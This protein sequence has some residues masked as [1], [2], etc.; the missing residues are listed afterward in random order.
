MR[1]AIFTD[2]FWPQINGVT[3]SIWNMCTELGKQGHEFLIFAPKQKNDHVMLPPHKGKITIRWL[4]AKPLPTYPDYLIAYSFS[5]EDKQAMQNFHPDVIH[6]HTPFYVAKKGIEWGK[7]HNIPV[8]GT[9]HTLISEF[10]DYV[11]I[12]GLKKAKIAQKITWAYTRHF[13]KDCN[14]ITTP[15]QVLVDELQEH[16]FKNVQ[17]L[18]NGIDYDAFSKAKG[19]KP[20]GK[21]SI[22]YWGRISFEKRLDVAIDALSIVRKTHPN[23]ELT[24]IGYGPA[25]TALNKQAHSLGLEKYVHFPGAKK[26]SEV[27]KEVAKHHLLVAPSPMETYGMYVLEA[28]AAG[29]G[30]VGCNA[31]AIPV[32]LGKNERGLLFENGNATDCAEK[33]IRLIDHPS[34]EKKL[35]TN[36]KKWARA[37]S[38][39]NIAKKWIEL[40]TSIIRKTQP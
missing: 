15:T 16:G 14:M 37:Y 29:M 8:I 25:E 21:T 1:I 31:R 28:M 30:I 2:S 19:K 24:L 36:A 35:S 3:I 9:F 32:A 6:V 7:K 11:P 4:P 20:K 17:V 38:R 12:P 26:G 23:V 13:Y 22:A 5:Q 10:L 27:A 18:S 39:K 33:I 40:Y 34:L